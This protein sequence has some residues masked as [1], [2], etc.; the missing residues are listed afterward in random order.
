[1]LI[2][3]S[4]VY[5]FQKLFLNRTKRYRS[6]D[7]YHLPFHGVQNWENEG[8]RLVKINVSIFLHYELLHQENCHIQW[9]EEHEMM[10]NDMKCSKTK[11]VCIFLFYKYFLNNLS[12]TLTFKNFCEIKIFPRLVSKNTIICLKI[13]INQF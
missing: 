4:A 1:M 8:Q 11:C 5:I 10:I 13:K 3:E 6:Y 12:R 2:Y 7:M 9:F